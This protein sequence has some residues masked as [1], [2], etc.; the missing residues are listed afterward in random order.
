[1]GREIGGA[2]GRTGSRALKLPEFGGAQQVR[3]DREGDHGEDSCGGARVSEVFTRGGHG[4]RTG[5]AEDDGDGLPDA[6]AAR[7]RADA[8]GDG[9]QRKDV[10]A[11]TD[12]RQRARSDRRAGGFAYVGGCTHFV[13]VGRGGPRDAEAAVAR[14]ALAV[15]THAH[16]E[17]AAG[18]SGGDDD[19]V[20]GRVGRVR[21]LVYVTRA[22]GREAEAGDDH[23]GKRA[24]AAGDEPARR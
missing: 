13:D 24:L 18:E 6:S 20:R 11:N 7:V 1:V 15:V 21:D 10:E 3:D 19:G 14:A 8:K 17:R 12:L 23:V 16:W 22:P 5:E 4:A 2:I 9:K